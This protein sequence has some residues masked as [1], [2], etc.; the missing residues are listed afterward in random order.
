MECHPFAVFVSA[1]EFGGHSR[2]SGNYFYDRAGTARVDDFTGQSQRRFNNSDRLD[3][4]LLKGQSLIVE[5]QRTWKKRRIAPLSDFGCR[6]KQ[7]SKR[8]SAKKKTASNVLERKLT[9][10]PETKAKSKRAKRSEGAFSV[11]KLRRWTE[12][13]CF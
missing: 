12:K 11:P 7:P 8:T 6:R 2:G 3:R 4:G 1:R 10:F 9:R 13:S 5:Y